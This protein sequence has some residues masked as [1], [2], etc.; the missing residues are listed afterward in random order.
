MKCCGSWSGDYPKHSKAPPYIT[1]FGGGVG[2][3]PLFASPHLLT[4]SSVY[5]LQR[6][7]MDAT[8]GL[9]LNDGWCSVCSILHKVPRQSKNAQANTQIS[10]AASPSFGPEVSNCI[11]EVDSQIGDANHSSKAERI[12][13][14]PRGIRPNQIEATSATHV[15]EL[16]RC[17]VRLHHIETFAC[18]I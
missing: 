3:S 6:N 2:M 12:T 16:F 18:W 5:N 15:G 1:F 9:L 14:W 10:K 7:K 13:T 4:S 17:P 8:S 11:Y